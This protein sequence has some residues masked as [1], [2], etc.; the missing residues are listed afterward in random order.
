MTRHLATALALIGCATSA[1]AAKV[2]TGDER[3]E[4]RR[5]LTEFANCVARYEPDLAQQYVLSDDRIPEGEWRKLT[6]KR[7]LKLNRGR[8]AMNA[9]FFRGALAQ[10]LLADG[11]LPTPADFSGVS[12]VVYAETDADPVTVA[13]LYSMKLGECVAR[14]NPSGAIALFA[15]KPDSDAETNA[16]AAIST[17]IMAC[18]PQGQEVRIGKA[19]LRSGMATIYAR[20]AAKAGAAS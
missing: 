13:N 7:C 12:P 11:K 15:S 14:R 5:V 1:A 9:F 4:A 10:R 18:V 2:P 20:M 6:D 19:N 16:I 17:D 8:L 3:A